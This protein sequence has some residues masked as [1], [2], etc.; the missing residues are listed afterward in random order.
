MSEFDGPEMTA[1]QYATEAA[2]LF[3][4][5]NIPIE[6]QGALSHMACTYGWYE[7]CLRCLGDYIDALTEPINDFEKRIRTEEYDRK[8]ICVEY[9]SFLTSR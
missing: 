9:G 2:K 7:E 3:K 5:N 8:Q 6:F 4:D 1:E